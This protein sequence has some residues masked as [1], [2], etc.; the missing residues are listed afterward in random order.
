MSM[1]CP[2]LRCRVRSTPPLCPAAHARRRGTARARASP[3][4]GRLA[5][6][7]I[8]CEEQGRDRSGAQRTVHRI[9]DGKVTTSRFV[10]R[11][12]YDF[13]LVVQ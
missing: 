6:R 1:P 9:N 11:R 7:G 12:E 2:A 8:R 13:L 4:L 3:R 5:R 10:P